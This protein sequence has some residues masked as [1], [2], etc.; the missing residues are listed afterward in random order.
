MNGIADMPVAALPGPTFDLVYEGP[1]ALKDV[2]THYCPG[3]THGIIHRMVAETIDELGIRGR[4]IGVPTANL[5]VGG[6]LLPARGV[7]AGRARLPGGSA[8]L[9][10]VNVGERPT[11]GG[12]T[13]TVEAHLL[14]YSGDLYGRRLRLSFAARLR[15]EERFP[16]AAALVE[17][18][19][20][21]I[22]RARSLVSPASDG[23]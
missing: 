22:D 19:R 16:G 7:Y 2:P 15:G 14:D 18:I 9:A 12:H 10:V 1:D 17:Q 6:A 11:F 4:T 23:V 21:D 3:C 13:V 8:R 5:D 20:R